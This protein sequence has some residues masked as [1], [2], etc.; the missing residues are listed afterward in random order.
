MHY[1]QCSRVYGLVLYCDDDDGDVDA[2]AADDVLCV[3]ARA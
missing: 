2:A 3:C 1:L